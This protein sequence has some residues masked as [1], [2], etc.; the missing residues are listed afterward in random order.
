MSLVSPGLEISVIDESQY[1]PTAVGTVLFVLLATAQDKLFNGGPATYTTKANAGKLLAVTS[2]RDL[3]T[4]FGYPTFLQSAAGTPMHGHELNEYGLMAAY[5]SLGVVNRMYIIRAD[6]DLAQLTGTEVRPVGKPANGLY[7]LD[8]ATTTWGLYEWQAA[9]NKQTFVNRTPLQVSLEDTVVDVAGVLT[10]APRI[11]AIGTYAVVVRDSLGSAHYPSIN[12][13]FYKR[14]DNVWVQVGSTEWQKAF[15]TVT[16]TVS[17]APGLLTTGSSLTINTVSVTLAFGSTIVD[18]KDYINAAHIPGVTAAVLNKR[19]VLYVTSAA[20]SNGTTADG[21]VKIDETDTVNKPGAAMGIMLIDVL[22]GLP[23]VTSTY[24]CPTIS[25]GT[26]V[27]IP[28][29]R[30]YD[31]V[32]RPSGSMWIK[33]SLSGAGVNLSFSEYNATNDVWTPVAAPIYADEATAIN[34]FDKNTGGLSIQAGTIYVKQDSMDDGTVSF[35]PYIRQVSGDMQ[36]TSSAVTTGTFAGTETFTIESTVTNA[37]ALSAPVT[38]A[39]PVTTSATTTDA[40]IE[41]VVS[42]DIPNVIA[43]KE[44]SGKITLVHKNGGT[45]VLRNVIGSPLTVAGFSSSTPGIRL[46]S[47]TLGFIASNFAALAYTYSASRPANDPADGTLWFYNSALDVDI[48]INDYED[49]A[50]GSGWHGYRTLNRDA[51]G[52]DLSKTDSNGPILSPLAPTLQ[53]NGLTA[54]ALGELWIN[55]SSAAL[56]NFPVISRWDGR[57]WQLINNTDI[58]SQN[59]VVFADARWDATVDTITLDPKGGILNPITDELPLIT[60]MINSNYIDLDCPDYRLYPRGT[61]LFNLRRSGFNVKHYVSD[62]FNATAYPDAA[63]NSRLP[64]QK[65][66]WVTSSGLQNDGSP[67]M[68]HK[69]QRIMITKAMKAAIDGNDS[70]REE[71]FDFNLLAA[72]GYPELIQNM[73]QLNNDR[74]DTGFIIGDT[75]MHLPASIMPVTAWSTDSAGDGLAT[76]DPY[77]AVYY[78]SGLSN[79]LQGNTIVVP[80]SHMILRAA[81]KNDQVAFPWF[82]FAGTRRG[83]IDNATDIGYVDAATGAWVRNGLNQGMRDALYT[84]NIN[85][86]TLLPGAGLLNFGNKTRQGTASAMDRVNVARLVNYLRTILAHIGDG[87]L[88]E[89]N[90]KITRSQIKQ[91]V[92]SA[93]NDLIAK[94]GIYDYLVVCDETNNTNDRIARNELYIDVYVEPMKAVEFIYVPIRLRNPGGIKSGGK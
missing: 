82:A 67:Y 64:A 57:K 84:L 78:P 46:T 1:V 49:Q 60:D 58:V 37:S 20:M 41:A 21:K 92:D 29:W 9:T 55:T 17:D 45:L 36:L 4:N 34:A 42:A 66:T 87:F 70:V 47:D 16:G 62:Y 79:D 44:T 68:G 28:D 24:A 72:P 61:L 71:S 65:G 80:P 76:A 6:I 74:K 13:M 23:K 53:S 50:T 89:P 93:I 22:T 91:A 48:M 10:P 19:L 11:G 14:S 40:F 8:L 32:P 26:Y 2:Q 54:L 75:P 69:A 12:T 5:S 77:M 52:Y 94:R 56:E 27:Q 25:Y 59:G 15:P 31:S 38:I 51:R 33:T 85:P 3:I 83:L 86:I 30:Y 73:V 43:R 39:L 63:D 18:F 90:D 7:W 35:R 88:F 81:I